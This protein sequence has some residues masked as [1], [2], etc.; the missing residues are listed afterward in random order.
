MFTWLSFI[1]ST[2]KQGGVVVVW[3]GVGIGVS[4]VFVVFSAVVVVGR[5]TPPIVVVVCIPVVDVVSSTPPF[6]VVV[7]TPV[8]AVVV[9]TGTNVDVVAD[10]VKHP[11]AS[12]LTVTEFV[13]GLQINEYYFS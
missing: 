8:V 13:P 2:R 9:S 3:V 6:V 11:V 10:G 4:G 1:P 5:S 12:I 7:C